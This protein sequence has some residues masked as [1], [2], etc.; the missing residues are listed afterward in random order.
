MRVSA[1]VYR[2]YVSILRTSCRFHFPNKL[3]VSCLDRVTTSFS[4]IMSSL[5]S[6]FSSNCLR[7]SKIQPTV[8]YLIPTELTDQNRPAGL[9]IFLSDQPKGLFTA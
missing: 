9:K 5:L 2:G 7:E 8:H 1:S 3:S 6:S 4:I